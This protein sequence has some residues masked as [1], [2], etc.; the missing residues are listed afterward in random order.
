M[1]RTK[2]PAAPEDEDEELDEGKL[3]EANLKVERS[4]CLRNNEAGQVR[5]NYFAIVDKVSTTELIMRA[6][7]NRMS[8]YVHRILKSPSQ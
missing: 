1:D 4:E 2:L 8:T 6:Y 7:L 5:F 3:F